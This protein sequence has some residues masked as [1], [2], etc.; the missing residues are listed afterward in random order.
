[1][2]GARA[3]VALP[4]RVSDRLPHADA[5]YHLVAHVDVPSA[6]RGRRLTLAF[7]QLP[8]RASLTANGAVCPPLSEAMRRGYRGYTDQLAFRVPPDATRT[9]A[10]DLD[11][12]VD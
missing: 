11:L 12:T 7:P 5:T 2:G 8:A 9:G 1:P 6:W 3:D 10:I 4:A